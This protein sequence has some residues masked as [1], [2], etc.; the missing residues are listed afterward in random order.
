MWVT[1]G[2]LA[3]SLVLMALAMRYDTKDMSGHDIDGI[4]WMADPEY[5]HAF[6]RIEYMAH[7]QETALRAKHG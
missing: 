6:C 4:D 2:I 7:K 3:A 1:F 5:Y